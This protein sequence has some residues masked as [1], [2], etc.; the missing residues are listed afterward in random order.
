MIV[1]MKRLFL[2]CVADETART[3]SATSTWRI[4]T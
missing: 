3:L 2:L 1:P 4:L